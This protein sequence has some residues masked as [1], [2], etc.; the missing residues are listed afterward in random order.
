MN[1]R[2]RA[3][4]FTLNNWTEDARTMLRDEVSQIG[5][6]LC[7]SPEMGSTGT[8]H[9]QGYVYFD[10]AKTF[11][12]V[13]KI[14][15]KGSHIEVAKGSPAENAD[16]CGEADYERD[17]KKKY[18]NPLF[19]SFGTKPAQGKRNDL[20]TIKEQIASGGSMTQIIE[21][22]SNYQSL[23][24]AELLLKYKEKKRNFKPYVIWIH[25]ES[26]SGKT[27]TAYELMPD[28]YRKTNSSGKWWDGYDAHPDVLLDD[29]K[30]ASQS[31]YSLLLELLD[32]YDVRVETKGGSRQFLASRIYVTS[33]LSPYELF[34]HIDPE[35]KELKRRIDEIKLY[36]II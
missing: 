18:K 1:T 21:T 11:A 6:Y 17:K 4:C 2:S 36:S 28:L 3:W 23:K 12:K 5:T 34:R 13:L 10:N 30:D 33:I 29:I 8:P 16:Y 15:P 22:A 9:L 19:E 20:Q 27:K 35:I 24:T 26:G 7:F 32:R 31:N 25:G 14:L